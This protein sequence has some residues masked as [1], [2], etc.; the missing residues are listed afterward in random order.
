MALQRHLVTKTHKFLQFEAVRTQMDEM[1]LK[2]QRKPGVILLE[3]KI[4][5]EQVTTGAVGHQI[6]PPSTS[7]FQPFSGGHNFLPI[8][9]TTFV[10]HNLNRKS[11]LLLWCFTFTFSI[12]S[13]QVRKYHLNAFNICKYIFLI[14]AL[15]YL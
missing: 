5:C 15:P 1:Q 7:Q 6:L 4:S 14:T 2:T 10:K 8:R 3:H 12:R 13:Y 11:G 9:R